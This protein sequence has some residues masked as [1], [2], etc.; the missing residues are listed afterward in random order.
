MIMSA[1]LELAARTWMRR[2]HHRCEWKGYGLRP[3]LAFWQLRRVFGVAPIACA[4][5]E[6]AYRH[7]GP[8]YRYRGPDAT[9]MRNG[10]VWDFVGESGR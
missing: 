6:D 7:L 3:W 1:R 2:A 5:E 4:A 10:A 9:K 8:K